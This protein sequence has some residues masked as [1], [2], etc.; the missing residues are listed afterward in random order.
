MK[1]IH[2]PKK[3]QYL[4]EVPEFKDGYPDNSIVDKQCTGVGGTNLALTNNEAYVV[5]VHALKMI[6]GKVKQD[7]YKHALPVTGETTIVEIQNYVNIR[8]N[9]S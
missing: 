9:M 7:K 4:S 1:I 3:Y 2:I 5:A 6:K 8:N